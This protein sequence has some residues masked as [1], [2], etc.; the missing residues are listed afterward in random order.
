MAVAA[1]RSNQRRTRLASLVRIHETGTI[2]PHGFRTPMVEAHAGK[3]R[4]SRHAEMCCLS[5]SQ[6]CWTV[7]KGVHISVLSLLE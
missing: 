5:V 6:S 7:T 3:A 4:G 1:P 2:L